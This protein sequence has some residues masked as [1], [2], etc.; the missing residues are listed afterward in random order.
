MLGV[1]AP[2][3]PVELRDGSVLLRPYRRSDGRAWAAVRRANEAWLAQWEPTPYGSWHELNS[4]SAYRAV[5]AGRR[6][7]ARRG[8]AMPFAICVV[9][10]AGEERLAGQLTLSNI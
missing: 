10:S 1:N 3:W 9:D 6:R 7:A 5:Y 8:S 2:G 4:P